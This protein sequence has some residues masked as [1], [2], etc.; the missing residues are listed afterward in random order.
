MQ[1]F[2]DQNGHWKSFFSRKKGNFLYERLDEYS[3]IC[4]STVWQMGEENEK[5]AGEWRPKVKES[6]IAVRLFIIIYEKQNEF[7]ALSFRRETRTVQ[8][9]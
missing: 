3:L 1:K 6:L 4:I 8:L 7:R 5:S 9:L 2:S